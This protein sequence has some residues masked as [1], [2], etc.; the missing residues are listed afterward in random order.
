MKEKGIDQYLEAAKVVRG[1]R[2]LEER[3][4]II[5]ILQNGGF[6]IPVVDVV[7]VDTNK[8]DKV[9]F[10]EEFKKFLKDNGYSYSKFSKISGLAKSCIGN[11]ATGKTIADEKNMKI[12]EE[13]GFRKQTEQKGGDK[14]MAKEMS[15]W[16]KKVRHALIDRN[17]NIPELA[18]EVGFNVTYIYDVFSGARPGEKLKAAINKYLEIEGD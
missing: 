4:L 3:N 17:M 7:S 13:H 16:E 14:K 12:L 6:N 1:C 2:N 10:S 5:G 11:Y 9:E 18:A 15:A 8:I